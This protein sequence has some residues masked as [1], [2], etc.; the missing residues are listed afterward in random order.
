MQ[1]PV[2]PQ[3]DNPALQDK[4]KEAFGIL[5]MYLTPKTALVAGYSGGKDSTVVAHLAAC[6]PEFAGVAHVRTHTG[7]LSERHSDNVKALAAHYGWH[8]LE[9][10]SAISYESTLLSDGF[11]GPAA[12][13]RM[14]IKLKERAFNKLIPAIRKHAKKER[15]LFVTGIRSQESMRR[16]DIPLF[17][18]V[19]KNEVWLNPILSWSDADVRA[20]VDA[21]GLDVPNWSVS[22]DCLCGSFA[23]SDERELIRLT[24]PAQFAYLEALETMVRAAR[25]VQV[26]M[27]EHGGEKPFDEQYCQWGHG[28][29]GRSG[30]ED[31]QVRPMI[32]NDCDNQLAADGS[33]N[34]GES[35][36]LLTQ[37]RLAKIAQINEGLKTELVTD[38]RNEWVVKT[39]KVESE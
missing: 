25:Q 14:Y 7:P 24:E 6:F 22:K 35:W 5:S 26:V 39:G 34:V 15:V 33:G 12:H 27:H 28:K 16:R 2:M 10:S 4:I 17:D 20:Y 13:T 1:F 32:C 8:Y 19:S 9:E 18:T 23:S 11:P 38:D 21:F 29:R 31:K 3:V 30:K 36:D 37:I